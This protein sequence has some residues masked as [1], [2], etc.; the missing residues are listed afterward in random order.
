MTDAHVLT[1]VLAGPGE[2]DA[3]WFAGGLL[4]F[5]ATTEQTGGEFFVVEQH[6]RQGFT[7]P[8][9]VQAGEAP[10]F[11][12]LEGRLTFYIGNGDPVT[13]AA[14]MFAYIPAGI[15]HAFRVESETARLLKIS[16]PENER[17]FRAAGEPAPARTLPPLDDP[18]SQ[19]DLE[20][21]AA[22]A[23]QFGVD[24]IG[25]PPPP[26]GVD[27]LGPA[28]VPNYDHVR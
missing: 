23:E 3:L 26:Q 21:L 18:R 17:F 12:V 9:H 22:A 2:G 8:V 11:Y 4:T 14:G 25:P 28:A 13:A 1:P 16:I 15:P 19:M 10:S 6:W 20:K 5:K 7:T 24:I 27:P